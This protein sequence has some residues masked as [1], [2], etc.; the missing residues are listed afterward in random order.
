MTPDGE[1]WA[2]N[3]D[4]DR[5]ARLVVS[6]GTFEPLAPEL[7]PGPVAALTFDQAGNLFL[8]DRNTHRVTI[9]D[10]A[11][12]KIWIRLGAEDAFDRP[13]RIVVDREG[14]IYIADN[15]AKRT[16][17]YR[18]DIA[19]PPLRGFDLTYEGDTAVLTW[20][21]GPAGFVR[22]YEVQGA[23]GIDGPYRP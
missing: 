2:W 20:Q 4:G 19:F 18:W 14:N 7:L 12:S 3:E 1:I 9:V 17:A 6:E 23:Q 15:G 8:L 11:R 16:H 5:V 21:P 22:G 13:E 10:D